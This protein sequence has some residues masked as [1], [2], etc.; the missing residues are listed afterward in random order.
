MWILGLKGLNMIINNYYRTD[1]STIQQLNLLQA[2]S[3]RNYD[4]A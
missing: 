4:T 3:A 2:S 1:W